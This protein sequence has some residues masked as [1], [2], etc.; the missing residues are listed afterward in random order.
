[1]VSVNQSD[2]ISKN[3]RFP[4]VY[5][6]R[7]RCVVRYSGVQ[8]GVMTDVEGADQVCYLLQL[9]PELL[10]FILTRCGLRARDLVQLDRTCTVFYC[11]RENGGV[12]T[13]VNDSSLTEAAAKT[14]IQKFRSKRLQ[15]LEA[16]EGIT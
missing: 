2:A 10:L 9:P 13:S 3:S 8:H 11:A 4:R 12:K 5:Q 7:A 6:L 14:V 16:C 1:V 15:S